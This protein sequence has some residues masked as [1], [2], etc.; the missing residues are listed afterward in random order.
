MQHFEKYLSDLGIC[1]LSFMS[2]GHLQLCE[3]VYLTY[4][5]C[6]QIYSLE[7]IF[8]TS[9]VYREIESF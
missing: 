1:I 7:G 2:D 8:D 6:R 5:L 3:M 9:T 4:F